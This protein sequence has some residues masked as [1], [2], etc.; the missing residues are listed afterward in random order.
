M[1]QLTT[2]ASEIDAHIKRNGG[3]YRQ[4]YA[5]IAAS[6][7]NRLF[8]DHNVD[9]ENG[10]WIFVDAGSEVSARVIEKYFLA[11]GCKGGGSGGGPSTRFVYAYLIT[12]LTRE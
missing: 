3:L 10:T 7:R 5:G 6:P 4:W 1:S 2:P 11:L 8:A 9:Q 12:S